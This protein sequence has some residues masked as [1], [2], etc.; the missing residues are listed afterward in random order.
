[1][2][3]NKPTPTLKAD[4]S[5][6]RLRRDEDFPAR[7]SR[8]R[9]RSNR[10]K[11]NPQPAAEDAQSDGLDEELQQNAEARRAER[12]ANADLARSLRHADEHDVHDADAAD[13]QADACDAR[14]QHREGLLRFLLRVEEL[15]PVD[16]REVVGGCR[17]QLVPPAQ[18]ALDVDHRAFHR[19]VRRDAH[20]DVVD[21]LAAEHALLGRS[22]RDQGGEVGALIAEA[23]ADAFED[24]DDLERLAVDGDRPADERRRVRFQPLGNVG[25]E[26]DDARA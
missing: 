16:D 10:A 1:M 4:A 17:A 13:D 11:Q 26:H 21:L 7:E 5:A 22:Q 9:A 18:H 2:P 24:A 6:H 20:A 19:R 15:A 23:A 8:Q 12:H 14:E 3:K 25:A